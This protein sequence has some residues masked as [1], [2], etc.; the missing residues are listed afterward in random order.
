MKYKDPK[1]EAYWNS[2]PGDVKALINASGAD[3]CSPGE[4]TMIG[5]HFK[6]SLGDEP[7]H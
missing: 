5:E 1:M 4:L 3:I 2:L 6:H 7:H